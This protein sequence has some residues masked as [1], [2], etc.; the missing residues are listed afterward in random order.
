MLSKLENVLYQLTFILAEDSDKSKITK[1]LNK[2][3]SSDTEGAIEL[4][5]DIESLNFI[6]LNSNMKDLDSREKYIREY[7]DKLIKLE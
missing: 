1:V 6:P 7:A 5:N 4:L 3:K 2:L